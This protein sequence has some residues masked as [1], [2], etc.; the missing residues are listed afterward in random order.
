MLAAALHGLAPKTWL[1]G[2]SASPFL[3]GYDK[4]SLQVAISMTGFICKLL[5]SD[6]MTDR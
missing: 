2:T 1:L 5:E 4:P 3:S 6:M